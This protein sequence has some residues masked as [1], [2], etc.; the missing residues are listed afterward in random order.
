[1]NGTVHELVLEHHLVYEVSQYY[2]L[3]ENRHGASVNR[4]RVHAGFDIDVYGVKTEHEAEPMAKYELGYMMLKEVAHEVKQVAGDSCSID[5]LWFGATTILDT[6]AHLQPLAMVRLR[7]VHN[8]GLDEPAGAAEAGALK[9]VE[10]QLQA[11]G[12]RSAGGRR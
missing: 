6:R 9:E 5:V 10:V 11:L 7:I 8:G 1:M 3:A 4:R 12:I 2:R